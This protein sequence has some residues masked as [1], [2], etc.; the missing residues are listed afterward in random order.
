VYI[1]YVQHGEGKTIIAPYS[2]RGNNLPTVATPLHW[3]EVKESMKPEEFTLFTVVERLKGNKD[4]FQRFSACKEKQP[5]EKVLS[6]L[7]NS[8]S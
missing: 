5:F 8:P 6:F 7:K 1:D 2:L 3:K 4:P